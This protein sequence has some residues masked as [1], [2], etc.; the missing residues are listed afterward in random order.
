[1]FFEIKTNPII[2]IKFDV[3]ELEH[4]VLQ[5]QG[6]LEFHQKQKMLIREGINEKEQRIT[7]LVTRIKKL[8]GYKSN[9][10]RD[11]NE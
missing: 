6:L 9:T 1:M 11:F 10:R 3:S 2:K 7:E 8:E 4:E 5:M